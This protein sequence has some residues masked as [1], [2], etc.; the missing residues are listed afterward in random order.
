MNK[1]LKIFL[2]T[3]G[4][5]FLLSIFFII[6]LRVVKGQNNSAKINYIALGDSIAAGYGLEGYS[7][8]LGSIPPKASYQMQLGSILDTI[9]INLA[10]TGQKSNELIEQ[11]SSK[12]LDNIL[13]SADY[14][15]ISIGSND[16]LKPFVNIVFEMFD[17]T[18]SKENMFEALVEKVK[19]MNMTQ[20]TS[21]VSSLNKKL[22]NNK[23]LK[24]YAKEFSKNFADII[25]ILKEKS[26]N[27]KI[28]VTNI[29]NPFYDVR[30]EN[31]MDLGKLSDYY[32]SILN[33]A[34]SS[35][36]DDYI[37]VDVYT[38]FNTTG[39]TKVNFNLISMLTGNINFDPHPNEEGHIKFARE[40]MKSMGLIP[41]GTSILE[42]QNPNKNKIKLKYKKVDNIDGY[43]I[44][45]STSKNGDYKILKTTSKNNITINSK[46]IERG[47]K[48]YFKVC[49]YRLNNNKKLYGDDSNIEYIE[50]EK[51][52]K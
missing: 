19:S 8:E 29:Y 14:I 27:A 47:K 37:L 38:P 34:F 5:V 21:L 30:L 7:D 46:K 51:S 31:V 17:L 44:F 26:P 48:Y 16:L 15:T 22:T 50:I 23:Q 41:D 2:L 49:S 18:N 1:K 9:P 20:L 39:L 11:I 45:Y 3:L 33:K 4:S 12:D 28:Y 10:I 36:S 43:E 35:N 40:I 13:N 32:I 24:K 25:N 52:A 6:G 42:I